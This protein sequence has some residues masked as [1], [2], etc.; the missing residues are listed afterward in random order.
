MRSLILLCA[1]LCALP[2]HAR[3]G[4]TYEQCVARYGTPTPLPDLIGLKT[5]MIQK[6]RYVM[7][8]AFQN[9]VEIF[10]GIHTKDGGKFDPKD[11]A[12]F[13]ALEAETGAFTHP[14]PWLWLREKPDN[15]RIVYDP[16]AYKLIISSDAF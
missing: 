13:V 14:K 16:S 7:R 3:L 1:L 5:F 10:A 2:A 11:L 9:N 12:A 15:A 6:D 4:E 8:I